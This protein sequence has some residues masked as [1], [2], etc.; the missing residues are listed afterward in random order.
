MEMGCATGRIDEGS[1]REE[2]GS[3][4][5]AIRWFR[6][7]SGLVKHLAVR[8]ATRRAFYEEMFFEEESVDWR[9]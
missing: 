1:A 7:E 2:S 3:I 8:D 9:Y 5:D 6:S 4:G